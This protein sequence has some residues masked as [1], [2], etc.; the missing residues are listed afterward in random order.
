[1]RE[2][3]KIGIDIDEVISEFV[4]PYLE[5]H[6]NKFNTNYFFEDI[7]NHLFWEDLGFSNDELQK[8]FDEFN[9]KFLTLE[10]MPFLE[11]AKESIDFLS[12]NNNLF[13][14]SSRPKKTWER[15]HSF[16]EKN[17]PENNFKI[18]FSNEIHNLNESFKSKGDICNSLDINFLIEDSPEIAREAAE[19]GIKV[20]LLE[21]PWNKNY[22]K[23]ENII[24]VKNWKEI[25]QRLK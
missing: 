5:F 11:G 21:K 7:Q 15:T 14:I 6:N 3:M 19:K 4:R 1:M 23:H 13:I 2:K 22:E 10:N 8:H 9:D 24:K 18:I 12:K 20:F 17:F 25:L 16:F